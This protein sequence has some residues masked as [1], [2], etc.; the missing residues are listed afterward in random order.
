MIIIV[1]I[2]IIIIVSWHFRNEIFH[3]YS[4]P[5]SSKFV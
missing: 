5:L 4:V 1:I 2:I 3:I